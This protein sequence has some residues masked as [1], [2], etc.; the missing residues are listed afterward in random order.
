[1]ENAPRSED[2][3]RVGARTALVFVLILGDPS[4]AATN[5]ARYLSLPLS[6]L[7]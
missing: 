7:A 1:M 3:P 2:T 5:I 6:G 4:A